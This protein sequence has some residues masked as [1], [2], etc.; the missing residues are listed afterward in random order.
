[1][2]KICNFSIGIHILINLTLKKTCAQYLIFI[3]QKLY[4]TPKNLTPYVY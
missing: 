4:A 3:L 1:M 2:M